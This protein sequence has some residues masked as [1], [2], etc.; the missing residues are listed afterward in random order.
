MALLVNISCRFR[1]G[2]VGRFHSEEVTFD[3]SLLGYLIEP[4]FQ[5]PYLL[6]D[7]LV[8]LLRSV[9][10]S[11]LLPLLQHPCLGGSYLAV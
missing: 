9:Q 1:S 3:L 2:D 4:V 5:C 6:G 7:H 11:H 8:V 10:A